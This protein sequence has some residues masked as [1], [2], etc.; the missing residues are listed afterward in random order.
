M[1]GFKSR[2]FLSPEVGAFREDY[3][4]LFAT[5]FDQFEA[6]SGQATSTL[7]TVE[8]AHLRGV[9]PQAL[10][11]WMKCVGSCQAAFLLLEIGMATQAQV[12]I[13][14]AIEDLFFACAL[15][16]DASVL[17]RLFDEDAEQRRKQASGMLRDMKGLAE[18]RRVEL[19]DFLAMLPA[20]T[21]GIT[22]HRAAEISGLLDFYQTAYRGLSLLASHGTL[23]S[24]EGSV[25]G[26][27]EQA[28]KLVYG[29]SPDRVAWTVGI[30]TAVLH[31]GLSK[32]SALG[33]SGPPAKEA[34]S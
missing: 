3:R 12:L 28:T 29:P 24:L 9:E 19:Q 1:D 16:S 18:A 2:G 26:G 5:Q 32:V 6:V 27:P 11:F 14:S 22:A 23:A 30:A 8:L 7:F 31:L 25:E 10:L 21:V 34:Q 15:L 20:K 13:R 33:R 17:E 4:T